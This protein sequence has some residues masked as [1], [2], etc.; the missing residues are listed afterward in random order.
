MKRDREQ[1]TEVV[2]EHDAF[3]RAMLS[4]RDALVAKRGTVILAVLAVV[5]V[6]IIIAVG[7]AIQEGRSEARLNAADTAETVDE[8]EAVAKDHPGD[9]DLQVRLARAY[10][11]RGGSADLS[12]AEEHL[13]RAVSAADDGLQRAVAALELG[14]VKIDLGKY[15]EA[16]ALFD[17]TSSI[18]EAATIVRAEAEWYAGRSLEVLGRYEEARK[19]YDDL[20]DEGRGVWSEMAQFRKTEMRRTSLE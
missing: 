11:A 16:L 13:A 1:E 18:P 4:A 5:A 8:M 2:H 17:K 10:I 3:V 12:K 15:E 9:A 7:T 19:R 6:L 20:R 14:K